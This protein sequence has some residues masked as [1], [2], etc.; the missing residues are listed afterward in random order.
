[1]DF[2]TQS[3]ILIT[4]GP[5]LA[6]Y[7]TR[8]TEALGFTPIETGATYVLLSGTLQDTFHLNLNLRCAYNVFFE[9]ADFK[10][11][12]PGALYTAIHKL[13]W[14]DMIPPDEYICVMSRVST[15]AIDNTMFASLKVKDAVVDRI[16][17]TLGR[18]PD[19]GPDRNN[20]VLYLFWQRET[21]RLYINCSGRKLSDRGYRKI[22]HKA[23]L[24][25]TL[26]AAILA[27]TGYD[28]GV[29]LITPMCG[30]GTLAIEGALIATGRAP[31][32]LRSN[33][34]IQHIKGFDDRTWQA[35]RRKLRSQGRKQ[36]PAPIIATDIDPRA[37]EAARKNA[38][39]AGVD[40]L[41]D[42]T[43]CDFADTPIPDGPG[44]VLL[45]P[46]Y[47]HR[48]GDDQTLAPVYRRIGDFFKQ[49]CTGYTGY[50]FTGNLNLAK[51]VGLKTRRRV[52]FW[53]G[54][55]ECRLLAYELYAGT[56][57]IRPDNPEPS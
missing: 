50:I 46:E 35:L 48:V 8:E 9:L 24:R 13:P 17:E 33:Y 54:K 7:V 12:T 27:E 49:S 30:S 42:F 5:G 16:Q 1:M 57:K 56:R 20:A 23:P 41:I 3:R 47:G 6:P 39:T 31:G 40:H 38:V 15:P 14:E 36:K 43:C 29:P 51:Q 44:M 22:P 19:S 18:R 2:N 52:I 11:R 28:G 25:E 55:I 37:I 4:C 53:N 26:A 34:G 21:A 10:V 32:L 45:N